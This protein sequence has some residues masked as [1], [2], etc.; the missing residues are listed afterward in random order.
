MNLLSFM[1]NSNYSKGWGSEHVSFPTMVGDFTGSLG[2]GSGELTI[3]ITYP[4]L[5][6]AVVTAFEISIL[7]TEGIPSLPIFSPS[8][9]L[10]DAETEEA[11]PT[12]VK[13]EKKNSGGEKLENITVLS[14]EKKDLRPNK[15]PLK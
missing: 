14:S 8:D 4:Y 3:G 9:I 13:G 5:E 10:V 7:F 15:I 12:L 1:E 2:F 11:T 6:L